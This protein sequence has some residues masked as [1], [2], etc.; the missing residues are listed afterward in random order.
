[1]TNTQFPTIL[2]ISGSPR[3]ESKSFRLAKHLNEILNSDKGIRASLLDIR[4]FQLPIF[5]NGFDTIDSV[6][7]P[8]KP[9]AKF[10]FEADAY[11][12]VTPEY[13]GSYTAVLQNFFEHFPRQEK[14]V[15]GVVTA[16]N[17]SL[18]GMRASQQLLL[19]LIAL[20]GIVSPY[21]LITPFVDK[22]FD[23]DGLLLDHSFKPK[24]DF[25]LNQFT[26]LVKKISTE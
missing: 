12:I 15:Y 20:F 16:T 1:L 9:I 5:E 25:F 18:G 23:E 3:K 19:L 8:L 22:K 24:I 13:N 2:V 11:I 10:F 4:E 6:P 17:G 21:M 7:A 14:K 26:W